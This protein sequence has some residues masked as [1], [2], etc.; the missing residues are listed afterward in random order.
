MPNILRSKGNQTMKFSR[1]IEY[2]MRNIFLKIHAQNMMEKLFPDPFLKNQNWVYL[3][4]NCLEFF[5]V[6]FCCILM[7]GLSKCSE[8]KL[9]AACFYLLV[10]LPHFLRNFWR[11]TFLLFYYINWPNFIVW[12]PLI[13]EI[14]SNMCIIIIC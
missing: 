6:C 7:W 1:L 14:L 2:N 12:L 11:K 8:T 4:I 5:E 13:R 9:Q 3:G 10:S